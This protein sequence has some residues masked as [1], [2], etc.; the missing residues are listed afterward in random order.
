MVNNDLMS[1]LFT[2]RLPTPHTLG[3]EGEEGQPS[4]VPHAEVGVRKDP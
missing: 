2:I 1:T 3:A 4:E